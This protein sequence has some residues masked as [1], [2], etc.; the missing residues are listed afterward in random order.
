MSGIFGGCQNSGSLN[1]L[2]L[3]YEALLTSPL[4]VYCKYPIDLYLNILSHNFDKCNFKYISISK[5]AF[6]VI[7]IL[8]HKNKQEIKMD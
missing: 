3:Q 2:G 7:I 4:H 8:D 1:F 5:D 6:L